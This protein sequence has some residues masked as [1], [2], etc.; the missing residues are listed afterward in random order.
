MEWAH[1]S[2]HDMF[3]Y[4]K[5]DFDKAYDHIEWWFILAMFKALGF[6]LDFIQSIAIIFKYASAISNLKN[7]QSEVIGIFISIR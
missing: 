2:H 3:F 4:I 7:S 6:R 1:L 5:V